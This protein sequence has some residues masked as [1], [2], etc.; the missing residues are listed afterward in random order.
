MHIPGKRREITKLLHM[1]FLIED[2]LVQVGDGPSLGNRVIEELTELFS[3]CACH[4]IS[5]GT[6]WDQQFTFLVKGKV[7]MHHCTYA[8][9]LGALEGYSI[10]AS[11][12]CFQFSKAGRDALPHIVECIGPDT[13]EQGVFPVMA[14]LCYDFVL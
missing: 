4:G 6:E 12:L 13:I 10:L 11:Y 1:W 5:P 3:G 7:P 8:H 2:G 14:T 9:R